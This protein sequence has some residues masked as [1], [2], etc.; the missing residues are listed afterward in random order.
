MEVQ[1]GFASYMHKAFIFE[2]AGVRSVYQL[3]DIDENHLMTFRHVSSGEDIALS[4]ADF[5]R[6]RVERR[7]TKF[8]EVP[9]QASPHP[10]EVLEAPDHVRSPRNPNRNCGTAKGSALYFYV[11]KFQSLD[12]PSTSEGSLRSF[13]EENYRDAFDRGLTWRP[14]PSTIRRELRKGKLDGR[15]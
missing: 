12:N 2:V 13:L 6:L 7:V 14:S 3:V 10:D 15:S 5:A 9:D 4:A 11:S 8:G 1:S